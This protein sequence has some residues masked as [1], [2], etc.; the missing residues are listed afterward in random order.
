MLATCSGAIAGALL[1]QLDQMKVTISAA[2]RSAS[3]SWNGGIV[4]WV[5][6]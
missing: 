3:L 2:S 6:A 1:P 5:G 4:K